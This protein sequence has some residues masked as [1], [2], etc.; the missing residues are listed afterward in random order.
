MPD[1]NPTYL[2]GER[3]DALAAQAKEEGKPTSGLAKEI[4]EWYI[5]E[6]LGKDITETQEGDKKC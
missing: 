5:D 2:N 3:Y 4:L 1:V 6:M